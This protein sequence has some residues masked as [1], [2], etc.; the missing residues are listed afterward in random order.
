M[1]PKPGYPTKLLTRAVGILRIRV[2]KCIWSNTC[3]VRK[4]KDR[5]G[6]PNGRPVVGVWRA[7][8]CW[9]QGVA[10]DFELR[11]T[12]SVRSNGC[13]NVGGAP[14]SLGSVVKRQK[15]LKSFFRGRRIGIVQLR[16]GVTV[17]RSDIQGEGINACTLGKGYVGDPIIDSIGG[18]VADLTVVSSWC[19]PLKERAR[20][21]QYDERKPFYRCQLQDAL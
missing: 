13:N 1:V 17:L 5:N 11:R 16:V 18:S 9:D 10:I 19:L 3:P 2:F 4:E 14:R 20:Y 15:Q 21:W 6:I 7:L 8:K 12:T